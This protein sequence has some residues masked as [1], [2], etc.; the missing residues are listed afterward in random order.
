MPE[1][2]SKDVLEAVE[3]KPR[4]NKRKQIEKESEPESEQNVPESKEETINSTPVKEDHVPENVE[5]KVVKKKAPT[6]K[7]MAAVAKMNE[8]RMK[9]RQELLDAKAMLEEQVKQK[10]EEVIKIKA[11]P[12]QFQ[13]KAKKLK[14]D[15]EAPEWFRQYV[16]EVKSEES[17]VKGVKETKAL[18]T[19]AKSQANAAWKD[20]LVRD[21]VQNEV[22]GHMNR[23]YSMIFGQRNI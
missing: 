13:R 22:D 9:K 8:A 3:K 12:K 11:K 16:S 21:K 19:E 10:T 7:Q 6:E 14:T 5:E 1:L 23:M 4:K 18:K 15:D 20:G 2:Y 17:R